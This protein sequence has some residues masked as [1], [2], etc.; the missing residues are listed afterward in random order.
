ML[1]AD[2]TIFSEIPHMSTL[3]Q[4]QTDLPV[5]TIAVG[6][7][8]GLS[9][10]LYGMDRMTGALRKAAGESMRTLLGKLTTN[11][12]TGAGVGAF[13]TAVI[14]S[15]SVTT[16]LVVGFI[17]AGLLTM[18][19]SIGVI[20]GANVG[21]TVTAQIIAFKVTSY[22]L[23]IVAAGFWM[24][25]LMRNDRLKQVG[26]MI[27]GLGLIFLGMHLMSEATGP[28]RSYEPFIAS[29][30]RMS[31]PGLALLA[32]AV[33]TA[34]VQSS[35][36][37]TGI[38]IVLAAQR[39]IGLDAGIAIIL[40][41]NIGTCVTAMLATIG[42]PRS[43]LQAALVHVLFNVAG[44]LLWL[45]LIDPL[46]EAV[47]Q[48]GPDPARQVAN[49]HTV[50][51]IA[52][53][54]LF[55]WF[56]GPI[57]MLIE[58]IVPRK[59][60]PPP[61]TPKPRYINDMYLDTPGVGLD[62]ARLEIVRL[63]EMTSR[64]LRN[65]PRTVLHGNAD[66]LRKLAQMDDRIDALYESIIA[67]LGKLSRLDLS[68]KQTKRLNALMA[69]ANH[70]ENIGDSIETN[71]V[72]LGQQRLNAG[73]HVSGE[74]ERAMQPLFALTVEALDDAVRALA[75]R[76][77]G[78]AAAVTAMKGRVN[79]TTE[80]LYDHLGRRLTADAPNRVITFKLENDIIEQLKRVYYF[81]KRIAREVENYPQG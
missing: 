40:G 31:H 8:G 18:R 29:M 11:R 45:L 65:T 73:V 33:F 56:T 72:A 36:A 10:F 43:A 66:A 23:L 71:L 21:T 32:G 28:L 55:I 15:S 76:D 5:F 3:A 59:A 74:T 22:A 20:M 13:V 17:S 62:N 25:F 51:N 38:V 4:S 9:L 1:K 26:Q 75:D 2:V 49:A 61:D 47:R 48:V 12:F 54:A 52:N 50:F 46:A 41:A 53:T 34:I 78:R 68:K 64:Q 30:G 35:S 77:A 57:A 70:V 39:L 67:F 63:G 81:T 7:I 44:A 19:Q 42:A 16:V 37:T 14:Q 79:G 58:R 27:L 6:L 24:R 60:E 69:V 80:K